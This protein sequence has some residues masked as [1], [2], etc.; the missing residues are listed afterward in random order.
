MR[1]WKVIVF[2]GMVLS[3]F[4]YDG[5]ERIYGGELVER[6]YDIETMEDDK[7]II[8]GTEAPLTEGN[9]SVLLFALDEYGDTIMVRIFDFGY[10]DGATSIT[11]SADGNYVLCGHTNSFGGVLDY[12]VLV[13]KFTPEGDTIWAKAI[14]IS[15][16]DDWGLDIET[17]S[18]DG[19]I[20]CGKTESFADTI[21]DEDV[22]LIKLD[23]EGDT[24]WTN[25][26]RG[27]YNSAGYD[28][29]I[30]P[31]GGYI[32]CGI[33]FARITGTN[34]I[35][36]IRTDEE[37]GVI[38]QNS[39]GTTGNHDEA[40]SMVVLG[41]GSIMVAGAT[42]SWGA[43]MFD[44]MIMKLDEFGSEIW[45][46]LYGGDGQE[47]AS[48]IRQLESGDFAIS[49]WTSSHGALGNDAYFFKIDSDGVLLWEKTY[50]GANNDFINSFIELEDGGFALTGYS[51]SYFA[52]LADAYV[53]KVDSTG[54]LGY[55]PL[56]VSLDIG[57]SWNTFSYPYMEPVVYS[58][59]FGLAIPPCYSYNS[60][61]RL[62]EPADTLYPGIGYWMLY[63]V[64]TVL[65]MGGITSCDSTIDTLRPGWNLIGCPL[66][67]LPIELI[68]DIEGVVPPVYNYNAHE[69]VYEEIDFLMPG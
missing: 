57:S 31:D 5:W 38:W 67:T 40:Y 58:E 60:A 32:I 2:L 6:T 45:T 35:F 16:T 17:T 43:D 41:D 9:G 10:D 21:S 22:Y 13:M 11:K 63:P 3:I 23:S 69:R 36:L 56:Y 47:W 59:M 54:A 7:F 8:V 33:T 20:V 27:S 62:Y 25:F 30:M 24:L 44:C 26:Y 65:G 66:D 18:D 15:N 50:G 4:A 39:Y 46:N 12:D 51:Y 34:E 48:E 37:G 28:V 52:L 14:G 53:I 49:G 68:T 19:F 1:L 42:Q 61:E 64:D 29:E 55:L